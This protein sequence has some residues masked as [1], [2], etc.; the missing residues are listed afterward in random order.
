[1]RT[2][3]V[4]L[5]LAALL[6]C[7][8][9][10]DT[11]F[12]S[13]WE[14]S[15]ER[16]WPG[17]DY[18]ANPWQDWRVQGGRLENH[19]AGG[20]RNVF[21]L[22]REVSG[23]PGSLEV[24]VKLGRLPGDATSQAAEAAERT[25]P[26]DVRQVA[27]NTDEGFAGFRVGIRG[28]FDDYRD[29]A[30]RGLGMNV[31]ISSDGRVF[32]GSLG[33]DNPTLDGALEDLEMRF[34]AAPVGDAYAATLSVTGPGG[35]ATVTRDD[36]DPGWLVG[37]IAL[38]S[39]SGPVVDTPLPEQEV[40]ETGWEGKTG[41]AR[42]GSVRFWFQDWTVAGDK[43]D[44]HPDR[45]FGPILFAMHTLSRG[46]LNL[47]A[48]M[49]PVGR[50]SRDVALEVRRGDVW[51]RAG[52]ATIDPNAR[53]ARFRVEGWDAS[54]DTPY[55][56]VYGDDVFQ[57]TIRRDPVDKD[58]IVVAA[59]TGNND[60]GFPHA[61]IVRHVSVHQPDFLF[62]SGDNI[63][64]RV[65]EYGIQRD[66]VDAAILDYLRK[67]AMFGW[68]YRG[69]L[70]DIPAVAIPDDHDVYQGN[71][72]GAGGRH[73]TEY[74]Q[75]GQDQGGFVMDRDF[76]QAVIRTQT[77]NLP[78][79]FD[80]TPIEQEIAV[81]YT[82]ILYGGVSFAVLEDRQ[83]KSSP[84]VAV[85]EAK[86]IN[87]WAKNPRYDA[88]KQG[89][90]AG[91][92]L[93]G[94]RQLEFLEEW[95]KDWEG[96]VWMK[97]ALSQT[98]FNNVATLPKGVNTDAVTPTLEVIEP[99][100]YIQGDAPVQDHDSN[101]WPQTGRNAAVRKL[102]KAQAFHIAGDQHLGSTIQYGLD[103]WGDASWAI[104]VP[105]VANIWPRRWF[106]PAPGRNRPEGAPLYAGE[107]LDGFGNKMTVHAV[108]NPI[109]NGVEP[110]AINH[111]APGYGIVKFRR[112]DRSIEV[113]N[114]PR[115]VDPSAPDAEPYPGWP[116]AIGQLD[117]GLSGAGYTLPE[118]QADEDAPVVQVID[119]AGEIAYTLRIQGRTFTPPVWKPGRYTVTVNGAT[120]YEGQEAQR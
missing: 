119:A 11:D 71:I 7:G 96:G 94:E 74:G 65:G 45:A 97:S 88:S 111:R 43:I 41:T 21:L 78:E 113:A 51:E 62:Y 44:A 95:A 19:V 30:V 34:E 73:A 107:F 18:W 69:L 38:V 70:K 10:S 28:N 37:G 64:E 27:E 23:R 58:E 87:G 63:Y 3:A 9:G 98:I 59:F 100:G 1:M 17:S 55:R 61:D 49:A 101:G 57:G 54:V 39:S 16:P 56:V 82:D 93:L 14:A 42:G 118:V 110:V 22:T 86:I 115:W 102:R 26:S 85:P 90:V 109:R 105:S 25:D 117:N 24:S 84:T 6:S 104:C 47:T 12:T 32:I 75:S 116:I 15:I 66:P 5:A 31:G 106:P 91:A 60:L 29:S 68:E 2:F 40:R 92:T 103:E 48:Q 79:P 81:Y 72:W 20:D 50:S 120:A 89:D 36:I 33:A 53:T 77:S 76:V 108:S 52:E 99:G 114:W 4:V 8:S 80:P 35:E 13:S 46:T 67:W 83:W 112:A